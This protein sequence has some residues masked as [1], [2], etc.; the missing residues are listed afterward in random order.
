[1]TPASHGPRTLESIEQIGESVRLSKEAKAL[2]AK[3]TEPVDYIATLQHSGLEVDAIRV[4]AYWLP[5]RQAVWWCTLCCWHGSGGEPAPLEDSALREAVHWVLEPTREHCQKAS[6]AAVRAR[7][8]TAAGCAAKAACLAG[9]CAAHGDP[10][11]GG[12]PLQAA[13]V[14]SA[15]VLLALAGAKR[16]GRSASGTE[17]VDLGLDVDRGTLPWG[18]G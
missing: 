14:A 6:E 3:T 13:S 11:V 15:S 2:L 9:S 12:K 5:T 4:L 7:L 17:M 10:L 8:R 18:P 1:M 16:G